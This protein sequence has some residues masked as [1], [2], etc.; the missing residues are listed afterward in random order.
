MILKRSLPSSPMAAVS[1]YNFCVCHCNLSLS[2][3][4]DRTICRPLITAI[5]AGD[6]CDDDLHHL[7]RVEFP[8]LSLPSGIRYA[9]LCK[10][11]IDFSNLFP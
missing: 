9:S 10:P 5:E 4:L 3:K 11:S 2:L 8:S 1:L 7:R 6:F